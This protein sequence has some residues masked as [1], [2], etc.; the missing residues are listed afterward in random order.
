MENTDEL[1][2]TENVYDTNL[3]RPEKR[4]RT[5]D[6]DEIWTTVLRK[7]KRFGHSVN[8]N[9][10]T[11]SQSDKIEVC[12]TSTEKLPKQFGLAKMLRDENIKNVVKL[13]DIT[14]YKVIIQFS[15]EE[16]AEVISIR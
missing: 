12:I 5:L 13:N 2:A 9:S 15:H 3:K 10:N 16:S 6:Q 11:I 14:A 1:S 7:A 8:N 4:N